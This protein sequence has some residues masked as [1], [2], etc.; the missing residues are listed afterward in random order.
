MSR[1]KRYFL[2]IL[3]FPV[4]T[5]A[6][7][8]L[9]DINTANS[10]SHPYAAFDLNSTV[11][12]VANSQ[13]WKTDATVANTTMILN[14]NQYPYY[15]PNFYSSNTTR[16]KLNNN[17]FFAADGYNNNNNNVGTE[18]WKTDGTTGGTTLVADINSGSSSSSP[19]LLAAVGNYVY[20]S[21]YNNSTGR[22]LWSTDGN[23]VNF[24]G[25]IYAGSNNSNYYYSDAYAALDTK[26]IFK[27]YDSSNGTELWITDGTQAGTFLLKDIYSGSGSS[28]IY[29]LTTVGSKVYF[30]AYNPTYGTELWVTDG[31]SAGTQ[32]VV[33]IYSSSCLSCGSNPS[34]FK[35]LNGYLIFSAQNS[36]YGTELWKSDGTAAGTTLLKNIYPAYSGSSP[37]DLVKIGNKIFFT[38]ENGTIGRELWV[39][40]G[41]TA[42]TQLVKDINLSNSVGDV[43]FPLSSTQRKFINVNGTLFFIANSGIEGYELWKSDG[44]TVGTTLVKDF[45]PSSLSGGYANFTVVGSK[46]YF[47]VEDNGIKKLYVSDGTSAGSQSLETIAPNI[48]MTNAY[49]LVG[50]GNTLVFVAYHSQYGYELYK[51]DG[52]SAGTTFLKDI[53]TNIFNPSGFS[54]KA[55]NDNV[56]LF[57]FN[58]NKDGLEL[59]RTDGSTSGTQEMI[60]LYPYPLS[61]IESYYGFYSGSS[62]VGQIVSFNNEFY[63]SMNGAIWKTDGVNPPVIFRG[64]SGFSSSSSTD[65]MA[66]S[67]GK[68]FFNNPEDNELWATDGTEAGTYLVKEVTGSNYAI[69]PSQMIDVNGILFFRGYDPS[70]GYELWKSDGT[71][72]GT[73][74]IKDIMS[75][76][77]STYYSSYTK[78]GNKLYFSN[79]TSYPNQL[80]VSDGTEAGTFSLLSNNS[81][82]YNLTNLNDNLLLFSFHDGNVLYGEELWVSNGTVGGTT[83]VK[84]IYAGS[85]SSGPYNYIDNRNQFAV[86]KGKAY[87]N[88]YDG[89]SSKLFA[90][91]G[92]NAG[93]TVVSSLSANNI[94]PTPYGLFFNAYSFYGSELYKSDGTAAGTTLIADIYSGGNSSNPSNFYYNKNLLYFTA[95]NAANGY[96]LFVLKLCNDNLNQTASINGVQTYQVN[97][98][99]QATNTIEPSARINYTAGKSI[100]LNPGFK[101]D[102][103][104]GMFLAKIDACVH[105]PE[106]APLAPNVGSSISKTSSLLTQTY[107]EDIKTIPS[108]KEFLNKSTN[109]NFL[110]LWSKI[111]SEKGIIE[112]EI[113]KIDKS[114]PEGELKAN[115]LTQKLNGYRQS[116][117]FNKDK[118]GKIAAYILT[119][120]T[121]NESVS[122][123]IIVE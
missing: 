3:L 24:L 13:L 19:E 25:D 52:T 99:I 50:I 53:N 67:N 101:T 115:E 79:Y 17:M 35:E 72:I 8:L 15:G 108:I 97:N 73:T 78:V 5:H 57:N 31:T 18:L 86:Y 9:K 6:Q 80:M 121:E 105:R 118:N 2:F 46:L 59:W 81:G 114:R 63:I 33:D 30:S 62:S 55:S 116:V 100:L 21:A 87:F 54:L 111:N 23:T 123:T 83:I 88:A 84:D 113:R 103:P 106:D 85:S 28:N 22:E 109:P 34:N 42:G 60:N 43:T 32:M 71:M 65:R 98:I 29:N 122:E 61:Y 7:V 40:D 58:N 69:E 117:K 44:T 93:T 27:A 51:T 41:T 94:S 49:P 120:Q 77:N 112:G 10:S 48:D 4:I 38:A 20:F 92:T 89:S 45:L 68:L 76:I 75:G 36:N 37:Q 91:D 1:I 66:I 96:E 16:L 70:T 90:S 47:I 107:L 119:L 12:F 39:T 95:T 82:F 26:M 104:A 11:L 14:P 74:L 110:D 56:I 102:A 64:L